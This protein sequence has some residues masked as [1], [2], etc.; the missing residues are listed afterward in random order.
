MFTLKVYQA[1]L[2]SHCMFMV[3]VILLGLKKN[4]IDIL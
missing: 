1:T 2:D 3:G 4:V